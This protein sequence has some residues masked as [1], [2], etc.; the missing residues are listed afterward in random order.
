MFQEIIFCRHVVI[1]YDLYITSSC[2]TIYILV[3]KNYI[4]L[5]ERGIRLEVPH[6]VFE[7]DDVTHDLSNDLSRIVNFGH[8]NNTL[9]VQ[10]APQRSHK[11]IMW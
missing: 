10:W 11:Q 9:L 3:A 7:S 4:L 6:T 8:I 5:L 1:I 2:F